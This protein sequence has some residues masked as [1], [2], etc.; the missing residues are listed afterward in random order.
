MASVQEAVRRLRIE[1][2][3]SGVKEAAADLKKLADEQKGV[4]VAGERSE[5]MMQ[6]VE[7]RIQG[8]HRTYDAAYRSQQAIAKAE[9]DLQRAQEQGLI[10]AQRRSDLM[11][12]VIRRHNQATTAIEAETVATNRLAAANDNLSWRRRN[13]AFQ[14]VDIAQGIALGMPLQQVALQ[15]GFQVGQNYIGGQ[16]GLKALAGDAAAL[17]RPLARIGPLAAAAAVAMGG[18]WV[19]INRTTNAT[20]S[21]GN[22]AEAVFQSIGDGVSL[23]ASDL[24]GELK[25]AIDAVAPWFTAT[26][27]SVVAGVKGLGNLIINSFRAAFYDVQFVWSNFPDIM[28]AAIFGAANS[29]QS[30]LQAMLNSSSSLWNS[31][32]DSLNSS[33]T[34]RFGPGAK[35]GHVGEVNLGPGLPTDAADRLSRSTDQ[36]NANI[37]AIM[38][39]DPLGA[40]FDAVKQHAIANALRDVAKAADTAGSALKKAG[41][42][43]AD[44]WDGLRATTIATADEMATRWANF[45]STLKDGFSGI[46]STITNALQ[47]G[48]SLWGAFEQAGSRALDSVTAKLLDLAANQLIERLIIG[49]AGAFGGQ[50]SAV[51]TASQFGAAGLWSSGGYT[52]PGDKYEPAGV[53]HRG[54]FV[55]SKE[56]VTRAGVGNLD[57]MHRNLRGYA[58]G[59]H[60]MGARWP[61]MAAGNQ[62]ARPPVVT[63]YNRGQP[64]QI[65]RTEWDGR[66]LGVYLDGKIDERMKKTTPKALQAGYGISP[67]LKR[68][69]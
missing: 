26:W 54:E 1:A 4:A 66:N 27:D 49:L 17:L 6:S 42:D 43:G 63:I 29:L 48:T 3:S 65:E 34:S 28:E 8:L 37:D 22:V 44:A 41:K 24:Y 25:P 10:T 15:Q 56:A 55:F 58:D 12:M 52:G 7:R 46:G 5:R 47:S 38:S 13:L 14:G 57:A 32:I 20:V 40:A 16:G 18:L 67:R 30:G 59:G 64:A 50:A 53:V 2:T 39:S 35:F 21:F 11:Q 62:N 68:A 45:G 36:R 19:E 31:W 33:L 60:V 61:Q 23:L 69:I 51:S 9:R